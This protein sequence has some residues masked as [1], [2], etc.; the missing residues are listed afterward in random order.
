VGIYIKIGK[1]IFDLI[2]SEKYL[3]SRLSISGQQ[4]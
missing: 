1:D 3:E 2:N 4:S